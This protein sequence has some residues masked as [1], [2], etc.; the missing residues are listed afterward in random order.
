MRHPNQMQRSRKLQIFRADQHEKEKLIQKIPYK[1]EK[2]N[3]KERE[4]AKKSLFR[5]I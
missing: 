5:N 3:I 4:E 2:T 1:S